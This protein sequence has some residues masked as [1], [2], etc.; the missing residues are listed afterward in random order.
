MSSTA[1]KPRLTFLLLAAFGASS[2]AAA[3][4]D[5]S[6]VTTRASFARD[7]G[8]NNITI[9]VSPWGWQCNAGETK[10]G[11]TYEFQCDNGTWVHTCVSGQYQYCSIAAGGMIRWSL[12]GA[13]GALKLASIMFVVL[14]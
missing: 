7:G 13:M 10:C 1:L 11:P 5:N 12:F 14:V 6:N 9:N 4:I 8:T 3:C 2:G